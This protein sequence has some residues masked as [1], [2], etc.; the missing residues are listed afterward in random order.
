MKCWLQAFQKLIIYYGADSE[1]QSLKFQDSLYMTET[2]PE[3]VAQKYPKRGGVVFK[4]WLKR[5]ISEI[6]GFWCLS[7][8]GAGLRF[9]STCFRS[10]LKIGQ[11]NYKMYITR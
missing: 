6:F 9:V 5:K 8:A 1:K 2:K 10:V 7:N 4:I 11:A 3:H